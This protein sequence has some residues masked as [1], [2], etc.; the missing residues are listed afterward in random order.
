MY[1]YIFILACIFNMINN[2]SFAGGVAL[3]ATRLIYPHNEKEIIVKIYN[4]D[5]KNNYLIQSWISDEKGN[6][7]DDFIITPP[8]FVLKSNS[9]NI[10]RVIYSGDITKLP[11]DKEKIYYFNSKSIPSIKKE[12]MDNKNALLI[13]TTAKIKLFMRPDNL[14]SDSSLSSYEKLECIVSNSE[15]KIINKSPYYINLVDIKI[16]GI[17]L[18]DGAQ[19]VPPKDEITVTNQVGKGV[20]NFNV[21]NDYG[22]KLKNKQCKSIN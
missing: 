11:I 9:N 10:L 13:S 7:V 21:I 5:D 22:V 6:K 16:K 18:K 20:V 2:V 4:S 3:G 15:L 12:E 1:K 19:T 8:L 17:A 14:M